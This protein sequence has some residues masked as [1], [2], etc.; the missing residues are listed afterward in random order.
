VPSEQLKSYEEALAQYHLHP[1][2]KF[3][4]GDYL[5]CDVTRRR[6][7]RATAVE[8]IGKE[9]NRW[10]EQYYLGLDLDAQTEYGTSPKDCERVID[11]VTQA[12]K[13]YEQ[14]ALAKAAKVP[15]REVSAALHTEMELTPATLARFSRAVA[16]LEAADRER[17]E[18]VQELLETVR[19][20]CQ[21]VGVRR[22]AAHSGVNGT[23][24]ARV[25]SGRR[26]PS[27]AMLARLEVA[28]A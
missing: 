24:P 19:K 8:H 5:D 13:K 9:A 28:L 16:R 21:H 27:E 12:A 4:N 18:H 25:L 7:I 17:A 23:N 22:L 2:A 6:H 11:A 1:E 14:R 20:R 10:E 26:K 15:L 3:H